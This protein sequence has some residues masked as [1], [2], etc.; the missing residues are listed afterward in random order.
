MACI[1]KPSH[2]GGWGIRVAWTPEAEVVVHHD[3]ATAAQPGQP[4]LCPKTRKESKQQTGPS[5]WLSHLEQR[6]PA[7]PHKE[8]SGL[9][10]PVSLTGHSLTPESS[11]LWLGSE[12]LEI[13]PKLRLNLSFFQILALDYFWPVKWLGIWKDMPGMFLAKWSV[14]D[15]GFHMKCF[16]P[17]HAGM[18]AD[19]AV[20]RVWWCSV[21]RSEALA[22]L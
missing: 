6:C 14:C 20:W 17:A 22:D 13:P 10:C 19:S 7:H 2:S 1:C 11:L 3:C 12:S 4:R 18:T 9:V 15:H 21:G 16:M 8:P 5:V